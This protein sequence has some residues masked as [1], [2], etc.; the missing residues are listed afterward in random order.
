LTKRIGCEAV[1]Y[2]PSGGRAGACKVKI[3]L[4][5]RIGTGEHGRHVAQKRQKAGDENESAAVLHKEPLPDS[6]ASFRHSKTRAVSHQQVMPE[7]ASDPKADNLA[8]DGGNDPSSDERPNIEAV[9]SGGE[10]S[11]RDQRRLGGQWNAHAFERDE[12]CDNPDAV[13][14]YELSH[15]VSP[16]DRGLPRADPT[17]S[18]PHTHRR[19]RR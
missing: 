11:R 14:G 17:M 12:R 7:S 16:P 8:R 6:D 13:V 15:F 5:H 10:K 1:A 4:R 18:A 9:G 19:L 3:P 2:D